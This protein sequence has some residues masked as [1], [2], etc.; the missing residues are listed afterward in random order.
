[1]N[2]SVIRFFMAACQT[3]DYPCSMRERFEGS[4]IQGIIFIGK[5]CI[6]IAN[7]LNFVKKFL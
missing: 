2:Q 5:S 4:R 1:M 6:S 7:F 3:K